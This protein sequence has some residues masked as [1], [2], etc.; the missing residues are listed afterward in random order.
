MSGREPQLQEGGPVPA[1]GPRRP[2]FLP[3]APGA[4]AAAADRRQVCFLGSLF[5]IGPFPFLPLRPV[6]FN[7]FLQLFA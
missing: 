5:Q 4:W 6:I 2:P 3:G 7:R 1:P